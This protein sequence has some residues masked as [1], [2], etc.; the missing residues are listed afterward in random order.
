MISLQNDYKGFPLRLD[1]RRMGQDL[2]ISI[3]GGKIP[4][5]G[6]VVMGIMGPALHEPDRMTYTEQVVS[7][8]GHK[9]V[10]LARP[11]AEQLAK[12]MRCTVTV[13][14]GIHYPDIQPADFPE[15]EQRVN[16]L[17]TQ[18]IEKLES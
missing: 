4:H 3:Y 10:L 5:I 1:A 9:D 12:A 8:Q 17:V 14:C 15:I 13:V 16:G 7:L 6:G 11:I 18:L 2:N